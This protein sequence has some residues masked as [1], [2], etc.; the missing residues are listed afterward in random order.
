MVDETAFEEM[1]AEDEENARNQLKAAFGKK[2]DFDECIF[3]GEDRECCG[4]GLI[5]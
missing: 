5:E 4:C 1:D 3:C 2:T